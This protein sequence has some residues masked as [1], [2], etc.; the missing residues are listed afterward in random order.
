[1]T[2]LA[3]MLYLITVSVHFS[4]PLDHRS[5]LKPTDIAEQ[6]DRMWEMWARGIPYSEDVVKETGK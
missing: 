4:S 1:M 5:N 6:F 2:Y 3:P